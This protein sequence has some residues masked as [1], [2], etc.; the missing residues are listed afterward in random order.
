MK[1]SVWVGDLTEAPAEAICTSTNPRLTLMMGTGGAVRARGGFEVLRACEQIVEA[2][3]RRSGRQGLPV[4]SAHATT[5]GTLPYKAVIHCVASNASHLSSPDIIRTSV[6]N[7]LACA[8]AAGCSTLAMPVFGT[9]H[10]RV[11]FDRAL[12]AMAEALR[13]ASTAVEHVIVVVH[14][15]DRAEEAQVALEQL[16]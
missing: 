15:A 10:A 1:V 8:D 2:E 9:G 5:A 3:F 13:T 4:G 12:V 11:K 14:E 6:T 16:G 7:A